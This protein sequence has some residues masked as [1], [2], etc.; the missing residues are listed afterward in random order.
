MGV[1]DGGEARYRDSFRFSAELEARLEAIARGN[2]LLLLL[3]LAFNFKFPLSGFSF[4]SKNI[5]RRLVK[6]VYNRFRIGG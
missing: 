2:F 3:L 5:A 4:A 6:R 1:I